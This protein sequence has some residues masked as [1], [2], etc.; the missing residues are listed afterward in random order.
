MTS[1]QTSDIFRSFPFW[2]AIC[3]RVVGYFEAFGCSIDV[4]YLFFL[5]YCRDDAHRTLRF[6]KTQKFPRKEFWEKLFSKQYGL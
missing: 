5:L 2:L 4:F 3:H 1:G 6:L